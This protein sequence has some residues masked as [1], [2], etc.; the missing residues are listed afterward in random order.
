[1]KD[2]QK[3]VA[4]TSL[5]GLDELYKPTSKNIKDFE[6]KFGEWNGTWDDHQAALDWIR[7]NC[8]LVS[9]CTC[10]AY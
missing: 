3:Y 9:H 2:N 10:L 5:S 7:E 6:S 8:K 4:I 1:M